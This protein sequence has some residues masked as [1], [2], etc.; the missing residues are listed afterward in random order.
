[1]MKQKMTASAL[2]AGADFIPD[3]SAGAICIK[4]VDFP[5]VIE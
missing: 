4:T 1:M 5:R 3:V 2:K